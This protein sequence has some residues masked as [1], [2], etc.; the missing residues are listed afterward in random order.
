MLTNRMILIIGSLFTPDG[1][2]T[3]CPPEETPALAEAVRWLATMVG[4]K[5]AALG[6]RYIDLFDKIAQEN[7]MRLKNV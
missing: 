1:A 2:G 7:P 3:V 4:A 5:R 6:K